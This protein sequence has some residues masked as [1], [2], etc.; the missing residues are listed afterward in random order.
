MLFL[1]QARGKPTRS[2]RAIYLV[3]EGT[4]LAGVQ[5][6]GN[7]WERRYH[8]SFWRGNAFPHL[9]ALVTLLEDVGTKRSH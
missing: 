5:W 8:T 4:T 6:G 1:E 7:G 2:L 3:P 9:F